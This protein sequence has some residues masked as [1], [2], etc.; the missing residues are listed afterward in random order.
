MKKI[1]EFD[2]IHDGLKELGE[3]AMTFKEVMEARLNNDELWDSW[4]D[5]RTFCLYDGK[6]NIKISDKLFYDHELTKKQYEECDGYEIKIKDI[7]C[8]KL[9][10]PE[11]ILK[12][13][14]WLALAGYNERLLKA[15]VDKAKEKGCFNETGKGMEFYVYIDEEIIEVRPWY[16]NDSSIRSVAIDWGSFSGNG[17]FLRVD[18]GKLK[19]QKLRK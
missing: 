15:Y 19:E 9:L 10:T 3:E 18:D 6:G 1:I 12:H 2:T 8:N 16:V 4:I 13:E 7:K 17:W 11:E 5:C 14:G